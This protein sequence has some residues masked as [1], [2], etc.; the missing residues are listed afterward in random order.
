[1]K[2]SINQMLNAMLTLALC[3]QAL[4][5]NA[6]ELQSD[7]HNRD[8]CKKVEYQVNESE[9]FVLSKSFFRVNR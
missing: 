1:M 8:F 4:P 9:Y 5:I 6:V 3:V 7:V 2:K